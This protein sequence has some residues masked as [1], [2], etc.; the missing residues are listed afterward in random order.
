MTL[1]HKDIV[2]DSIVSPDI[3]GFIVEEELSKD[4]PFILEAKRVKLTLK[5][6]L[7]K[8]DKLSVDFHYYGELNIISKWGVN[9][10]SE[11]FCELGLYTPWYPVII[12]L[13]EATFDID[14]DI[15]S[16]YTII[17]GYKVSREQ[18]IYKIIQD[19]PHIDCSFLA[20][21][22]AEIYGD[23]HI[24]IYYFKDQENIAKKLYRVADEIFNYFQSILGEV[25]IDKHLSFALP[26]R[27][28]GGGYN[29]K[30]LVV[31]NLIEDDIQKHFPS[32]AHE[33]AHLWWN[34]ANV[35]SW[36]DWL[37]ESFA[38]YS[39]LMAIRTFVGIETYNTRINKYISDSE[40]LPAI[41]GLSRSDQMAYSVLYKK[42]PVLLHRF[43]NKVSEKSF[44]KL[45]KL[46]HSEQ[47]TNTNQFFLLVEELFDKDLSHT[48]K[49]WLEQ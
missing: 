48:F 16:E 39:S 14:I 36:E 45:L 46:T 10:I 43:E 20:F 40:S 37:N 2:I 7:K 19:S 25:K 6:D 28:D 42:G 26:P 27:P 8:N 34:K 38:E 33:I 41:K 17:N 32:I 35:N 9:R 47:V 3:S 13:P 22:N 12:S 18:N 21:K 24:K 15:P 23:D 11:L 5:R 49:D 31:M 29:R 30:G 1:T 4:C 44:I